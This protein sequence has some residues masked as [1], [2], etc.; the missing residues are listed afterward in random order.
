MFG[1]VNLP[2]KK[3]GKLQKQI[4]QQAK[5]FTPGVS[6]KAEIKRVVT[7]TPADQL[8]IKVLQSTPHTPRAP[9]QMRRSPH[10]HPSNPLYPQIDH[11]MLSTHFVLIL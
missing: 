9:L 3:K 6:E 4:E 11:P 8:A 7:E 5:T 10:F 1:P 2:K